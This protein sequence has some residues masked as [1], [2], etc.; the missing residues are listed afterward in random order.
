MKPIG[1]YVRIEDA[2]LYAIDSTLGS[3]LREHAI[4]EAQAYF[5]YV[6]DHSIT[7]TQLDR[8]IESKPTLWDLEEPF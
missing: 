8:H 4:Q 6:Q 7:Y 1:T 5:D 3:P 2:C